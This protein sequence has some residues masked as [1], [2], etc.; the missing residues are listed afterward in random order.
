MLDA[1]FLEDLAQG[2]NYGHLE[3]LCV[4]VVNGELVAFHVDG[5]ARCL[6]TG[7]GV[8][9]VAA[10][11][12]C[13]IFSGGCFVPSEVECVD[14]YTGEQTARHF[15][16]DHAIDAPGKSQATG[17]CYATSNADKFGKMHF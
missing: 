15:G 16:L 12:E 11:A 6:H 1:A 10:E 9:T 7:N 5:D 2:I 8:G 4:H 14:F 3:V 17:Q 13:A